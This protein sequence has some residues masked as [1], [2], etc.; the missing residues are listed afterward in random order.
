VDNRRYYLLTLLPP[1]PALGEPRP[2]T[3]SEALGRLRQQGGRDLEKLADALEAEAGLRDALDEWVRNQPGSRAFPRTLPAPLASLFAEDRIAASGEDAWVGAVWQAWFDLLARLGRSIGSGLLVRWVA[4]E[5]ALRLHLARY[6][7]HRGEGRPVF[8]LAGEQGDAFGLAAVLAAW[9]TVR[10]NGRAGK[11][12][13]AAMEAEE[14]LERARLD[15]LERENPRYSFSVD[16]LVAYLLKLR[17]L[18][19]HLRLDPEKGRALLS[20]VAAL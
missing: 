8:E 11:G 14:L 10:E 2:I 13:T 4:W 6:R 12:L 1:L 20:G 9:A 17:L 5:G 7:G 18:A 3:L 15:F 16:E 19:R